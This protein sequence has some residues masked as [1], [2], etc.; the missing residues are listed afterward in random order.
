MA[1]KITLLQKPTHTHFIVEGENT[2]ENTLHYIREI[3]RECTT[4][5]YKCIL[6]EAA[7][8]EGK[9]LGT[10]DVF[11]IV[12]RASKL[13]FGFFT[14]IAYV[15]TNPDK[16]AM[17]FVEDVAINRSLPIRVFSTVEEAEKW[18]TSKK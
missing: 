8:L 10:M 5:N 15:I 2:S 7:H 11:D 4:N 9:L 1:C 6:I 3:Y 14:A 13:G 18:L 17:K 12:S 16:N